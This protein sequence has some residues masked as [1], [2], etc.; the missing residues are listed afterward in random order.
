MD[1]IPDQ[2]VTPPE[3][4]TREQVIHARRDELR[5]WLLGIRDAAAGLPMQWFSGDYS[6][7]DIAISDA[8]RLLWTAVYDPNQDHKGP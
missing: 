5:K 2:H 7:F 4:R 8:V 3:S 1:R 6:R